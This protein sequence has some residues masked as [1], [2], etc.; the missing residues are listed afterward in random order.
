MLPSITKEYWY[1]AF[2][3]ELQI[4]RFKATD[5]F[6]IEPILSPFQGLFNDYR[7][8]IHP[9][10]ANHM[11]QYIFKLLKFRGDATHKGLPPHK[12]LIIY[13]KELFS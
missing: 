5:P 10:R 1:S 13:I 12:T 9:H 11:F 6:R 8:P 7:Q 4:F 3:L 2:L